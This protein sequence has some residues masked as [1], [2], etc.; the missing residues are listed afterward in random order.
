[1]KNAVLS[2]KSQ[3]PR[4]LKSELHRW[5]AASILF[6]VLMVMARI[7]YTGKLTFIFFV[8]NLFLAYVPYF[9]SS[10]LQ[11]HPAWIEQRWKFALVFITWLLFVPNSFYIITDLFHISVYYGMPLWFDVALIFSFAWN[12]L[13]L[14][15]LSVR[16][17][18]RI[19]LLKFPFRNELYF[20]YPIMVL[21]A[22]GVFIGRYI[23]FNSW[24]AITSPFNVV[25]DTMY[26]MSNPMYFKIAC[27][28][29]AC[30]S[31]LMTFMYLVLKKMRSLSH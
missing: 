4:V 8:W 13:V 10:W 21:N 9:I 3:I 11:R 6:S 5:L 18:E 19:F 29:V 15:V 24:D 2:L 26:V 30:Y 14:G 16:Q 31:V 27:G 12:G 1:M 17:M 23:R 22:F 28:M 7:V 25:I 20:I